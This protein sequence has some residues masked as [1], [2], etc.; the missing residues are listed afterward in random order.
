MGRPKRAVAGG[1]VYHVLNRANRRARMFHKPRDY[2][3]FLKLLV[4]ALDRLPCRLLGL[5]L[6][7]NHWHL[8]LW[9]HADGDLS[10]LMAWITNTHV[11]RYRQHYHDKI[12]GHLYQGRFKSF[13]VQEDRHLLT[14]LRYV[15]ANPLRA[16]LAER[17]GEWPWS[18]YAL[19]NAPWKQWLSDWPLPRPEDWGDLVEARWSEP[20]LAE[21]RTSVDRGRPFGEAI[22]IDQTAKKMGLSA[23]LRPLGRPPVLPVKSAKS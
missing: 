15:E 20:E 7:P 17:A 11:K 10:N 5:C 13:P 4:E 1:V 18:S 16:K 23:T 21:M 12:G 19:R 2:D 3:A 8:V 14:V 22:W 6:M 9:P